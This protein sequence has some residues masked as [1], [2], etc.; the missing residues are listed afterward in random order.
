LSIQC[1]R[2]GS[3]CRIR[4]EGA[5]GVECAAETKQ[6]LVD[7]I[8][9]GNEVRLQLDPSADLDVTTIQLLWAAKRDAEATGTKFAV[10]GDVSGRF[11][12]ICSEAGLDEFLLAVLGKTVPGGDKRSQES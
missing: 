6:A 10:A 9:P 5:V 7:A 3:T 8:L 2:E 12:A 11:S 1:E 4:L